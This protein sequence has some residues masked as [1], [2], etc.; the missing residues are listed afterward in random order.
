MIFICFS[1]VERY[2]VAQSLSYH[3]KNYGYKIWYDYD[4][5]FI[6]DDGDYL[7]FER[8]LYKSRYVVVIIS[9]ALFE[10]PCAISELEQIYELLKNKKIVVIPI[11][12]NITASE[13]GKFIMKEVKYNSDLNNDIDVLNTKNNAKNDAIL[14]FGISIGIFGLI[15]IIA[16]NLGFQ[17]TPEIILP[18]IITMVGTGG[19]VSAITGNI[20]NKKYKTKLRKAKQSAFDLQQ[21]LAKENTIINIK[22]LEDAEV[23]EE[24]TKST[25]QNDEGKI[26]S[27]EEKIIRYFYLLDKDD[28]VAVL[29][30]ICKKIKKDKVILSTSKLELF[31]EKDLQ[32]KE[33]PV[34]KTL[35]RK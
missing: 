18:A 24:V 14:G 5:L 11:L 16:F 12:Y 2:I 13:R 19:I 27:K 9:H 10:S 6:G 28:Q 21:E 20:S 35:I 3:L 26:L 34:R 7:N 15:E 17:Y 31:E 1:H 32:E 30:Q 23:I 33:L 22:S 4:E 8:G 29:R 25:T